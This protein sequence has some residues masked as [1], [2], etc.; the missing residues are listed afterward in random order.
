MFLSA[1]I[2][3]KNIMK[4]RRKHPKAISFCALAGVHVYSGFFAQTMERLAAILEHAL[5]QEALSF[6][7]CMGTFSR[8]TY[9]LS[10]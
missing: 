5:H 2:Y 3:I 8:A 7:S 1:D 6:S 4:T 9:N 10:L